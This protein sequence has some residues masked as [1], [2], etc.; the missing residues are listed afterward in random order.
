MHP[1][2]AETPWAGAVNIG[3]NRWTS[4]VLIP[5]TPAGRPVKAGQAF[6]FNFFRQ[7]KVTME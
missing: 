2:P 5:L 6:R 3:K 7:N 1:R 4:E